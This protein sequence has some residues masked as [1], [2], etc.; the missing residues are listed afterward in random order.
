MEERLIRIFIKKCQS[1]I[2][3]IY[4]SKIQVAEVKT[5]ILEVAKIID[6]LL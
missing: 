5:S 6:D 1:F 4:I 2:K 3:N